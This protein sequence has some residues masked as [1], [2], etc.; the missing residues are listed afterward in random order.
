M[1]RTFAILVAA[2]LALAGLASATFAVAFAADAGRLLP[3]VALAV[4]AAALSAAALARAFWMTPEETAIDRVPSSERGHSGPQ[5]VREPES[6]SRR[7][8]L[9][10][11]FYATV[12]LFG[13]SLVFPIRSLAPRMGPKLRN[14]GWRDGERLVGEG[15]NVLTVTAVKTGSA[16]TVFPE[17]AMDDARSQ[18]V[19]IRL[20]DGT[21]GTV[22]GYAVYSRVCTHAGCPV[23]LYR[24]S[25]KQLMCPCHQSVFDAAGDGAVVSG[26][27]DRP[28]PR[29]PIRIAEDGS[30]VAAGDFPSPV[31]PGSW[32]MS[33]G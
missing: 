16:I 2:V 28:L 15:G 27:A 6:T 30:I 24:A 31:G 13:L 9:D 3:G 25:A 7:R 8:L 11:F 33:R 12:G 32:S 29:L 14:T 20:P 19:L 22:N 10:R 1:T 4:G 17:S 23:A 21:E 26:P 5:R 18:A